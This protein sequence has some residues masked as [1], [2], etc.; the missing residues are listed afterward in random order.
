[1]FDKELNLDIM[2]D[3]NILIGTTGFQMRINI[4]PNRKRS[5]SLSGKDI[6]S[7]WDSNQDNISP[8]WD[9]IVDNGYPHGSNQDSMLTT[10]VWT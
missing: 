2:T 5:F 6:Q 10:T 8:N 3:K 1:M 7:Q 4:S 9:S